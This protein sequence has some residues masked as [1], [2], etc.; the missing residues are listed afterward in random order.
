MVIFP[1][2]VT[3][4]PSLKYFSLLFIMLLSLSF[5][6]SENMTIFF[7]T[8]ESSLEALSSTLPFLMHVSIS[9]CKADRSLIEYP[10]SEIDSE[11]EAALFK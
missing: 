4:K 10:I 9:P 2:L 6:L 7:L 11:A 1:F 5:A 8:E 3:I